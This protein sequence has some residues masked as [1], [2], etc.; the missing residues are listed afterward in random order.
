M[1][2]SSIKK[3]DLPQ[4]IINFTPQEHLNYVKQCVVKL[5]AK[6][7][8][9]LPLIFGTKK[10]PL[11]KW[12]ELPIINP[13]NCLN[14]FNPRD[15]EGAAKKFSPLT[16]SERLN[17]GLL[18]GR[19]LPNPLSGALY[20]I[21]M[22]DPDAE[23]GELLL[24]MFRDG[25]GNL[26][27]RKGSKGFQFYVRVLA[28]EITNRP[29]SRSRHAIPIELLG[30]GRQSVLPPSVYVDAEVWK[31]LEVANINIEDIYADNPASVHFFQWI[32]TPLWNVDCDELPLLS[33]NKWKEIE[34]YR[35]KPDS[36]LF[37]LHR[38]S[39]M[40]TGQGGGYHE[41]ALQ[42]FASY[43]AHNFPKDYIL[44]RFRQLSRQACRRG[45]LEEEFLNEWDVDKE[46]ESLWDQTQAKFETG[47]WKT[48]TFISEGERIDKDVAIDTDNR[49]LG[50][51]GRG[52]KGARKDVVTRDDDGRPRFQMVRK[53][54]F[55]EY[56]HA[57]LAVG[58]F[59]GF[60][61]LCKV[62]DPF[63][64]ARDPEKLY[65]Y[66]NG[67]WQHVNINS[68]DSWLCDNIA[69]KFGLTR[70]QA[71]CTMDAILR[72]APAKSATDFAEA[73][74]RYI[75]LK[76]CT[77]DLETLTRVEDS[78]NYFLTHMVDV[79]H[80]PFATC[81]R[82]DEFVSTLF[83][84][85]HLEENDYRNSEQLEADRLKSIEVYEEFMSHTL[86]EGA[87]YQ[88]CLFLRGEPNSGK[89]RAMEIA[90]FFHQKVGQIS[91]SEFQNENA[92][93]RLT[94]VLINLCDEVDR[95]EEIKPAIFK[96]LVG[97][98]GIS[99]KKL[100]SDVQDDLPVKARLVFAFNDFPSTIEINNSIERRLLI[101]SCNNIVPASVRD[102][103]LI[104]KL[105]KEKSGILNR[106]LIA[107]RR[108]RDRGDFD[109]PL[110]QSIEV[111][112]FRSHNDV[113]GDFLTE[114]CDFNDDSF[115]S[116]DDLFR[117]FRSFAEDCGHR[118]PYT[119]QS[120]RNRFRKEAVTRH[121]EPK[122]GRIGGQS[123]RGYRIGLRMG[124]S[125]I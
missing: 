106:W 17:L 37:T 59:G 23:R 31:E 13:E 68:R 14:N 80:D 77:L 55:D 20:A 15:Y 71:E 81:P 102:H 85:T 115:C 79:V 43:Y 65:W 90:K 8:Q 67:Y 120:F 45:G 34:I 33:W 62:Y 64:R 26:V 60:D 57:H 51:L 112:A 116:I 48:G 21:D 18:L 49:K 83:T 36:K 82:Y 89:T 32:T 35:S 118:F 11:A 12:S 72:M 47:D 40:G 113:L 41:A 124:Y 30:K 5:A 98:S 16:P 76:N 123:A 25:P 101:L 1:S 73:R 50:V 75:K 58:E 53:D 94:Q 6:G 96:R 86:V 66:M 110:S 38:T 9:T 117:A 52:K 122:V 103:Q 104:E 24:D 109:P 27:L 10:P 108:L 121:I 29:S 91:W 92:R 105:E 99:V 84:Q 119:K 111:A 56:E 93:Y 61:N 42:T 87:D 97:G 44:E 39:Y 74:K 100:Y 28:E 114:R 70:R 54:D 69:T 46:A 19:T 95:K 7:Y 3:P 107:L 78:P 88:K 63:T 4:D 22:D 2:F 125:E